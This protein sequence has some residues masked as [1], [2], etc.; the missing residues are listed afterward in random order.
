[1]MRSRRRGTHGRGRGEA[2]HAPEHGGGGGTTSGGSRVWGAGESESEG[3]PTRIRAAVAE[4]PGRGGRVGSGERASGSD[5]DR[6]REGGA[7]SRAH[8]RHERM[9]KQHAFLLFAFHFS[10]RLGS[11]IWAGFGVNWD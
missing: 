2:G 4:L 9:K 8:T 7:R 10:L 11:L 6:E 1:V 3:E 5:W